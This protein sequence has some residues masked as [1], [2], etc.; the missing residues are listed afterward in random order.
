MEALTKL[1]ET[2]VLDLLKEYY[3]IKYEELFGLSG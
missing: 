2:R 3:Q 1:D